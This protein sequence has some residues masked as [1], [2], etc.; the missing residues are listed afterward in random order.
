MLHSTRQEFSQSTILIKQLLCTSYWRYKDEK[1][2]AAKYRYMQANSDN[3][4]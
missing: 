4:T 2:L 1:Q 3:A